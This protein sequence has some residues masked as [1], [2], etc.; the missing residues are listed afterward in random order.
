MSCK[1]CAT[2]FLPVADLSRI[3]LFYALLPEKLGLADDPRF[4]T[5]RDRAA[6][7]PEVESAPHT[8][9]ARPVRMLAE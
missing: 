2:S 3:H 4:A 6:W 9:E 8:E 7:L 1:V 5:Q